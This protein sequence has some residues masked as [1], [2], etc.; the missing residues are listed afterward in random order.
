VD[1]VLCKKRK[2]AREF[3][4]LS[5]WSSKDLWDRVKFEL[6]SCEGF[7]KG[8]EEERIKAPEIPTLGNQE[9]GDEISAKKV[10]FSFLL[11]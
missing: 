9:E 11:R 2:I 8:I 6:R 3:P 5:N 4:I 10:M 7:G 1:R